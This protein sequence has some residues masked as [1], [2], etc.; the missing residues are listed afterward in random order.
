MSRRRNTTKITDSP[1]TWR[2][3]SRPEHYHN[4]YKRWHWGV[5]A[6]E[7]VDWPDPDVPTTMIEIG[8]LWELHVKPI[9]GG[10]KKVLEVRD[11]SKNTSYSAFDPHHIAQRIYLLSAPA[12]RADAKKL[13]AGYDVKPEPLV[14]WAKKAGGRH[15]K[16]TDYPDVLVKPVGVLTDLVYRTHKKGDDDDERGSSYIHALGEDSGIHPILT[17]DA[18]GRFWVAGGNYTCPVPGITD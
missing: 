15:G 5:E 12:V 16:M 18:K 11:R 13:W 9:G 2:Q 14:K 7:I 17:V 4:I 6:D 1:R 8:R 10:K 3:A